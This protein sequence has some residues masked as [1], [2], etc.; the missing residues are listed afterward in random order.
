MSWFND[1]FGQEIFERKYKGTAKDIYEYVSRLSRII[2]R[3]NPDLYRKF[4]EMILS[5]RFIPGGRILA[6]GGRPD[7]NVSLMNCTTHRITDDSLEGINKASY[8]VM[9]A[10]SRGQGI[11]IDLTNLRPKDSPVNN[12]ART[13]TGAIS[14]MELLNHVAGTIGQEGRRA[15]LLF[16]IGIDHPDVYRPQNKDAQCPKCSGVGCND[17]LNGYLP[18]DFLHVKHIPGK[19]ENANISVRVTDDF[20]QA[21]KDNKDWHLTFTG[22]SGG[23]DFTVDNVYPAKQ[24]F[25]EL[26]RAAWA[27][28]EPGLLYWNT[29][30]RMSNSDLFGDEWK[31]VGTNS[32]S[33]EVLDQDG[34]CLLGSL[35]LAAYVINPFTP[36]ARFDFDR[37]TKDIQLAI[38][39]LDNVIDVE[40]ERGKHTTS[41]QRRSLEYLRRIGL[42]VMGLADM[43]AMLG[44]SYSLS[45]SPESEVFLRQVFYNLAIFSYTTS[46][47][48]AK[49]R[50]PALAW[51]DVDDPEKI[52]NSGFFATLS[53]EIKRNIVKYGTR[54]IVLLSIAPTGTI[55]NLI[56]VT[57]GIEPLF[58]PEFTRRTRMSGKDEFVTYVHPGIRLA[59]E[60][61]LPDSVYETAYDLNVQDH[62]RMQALVQ[63]YVDASIAKTLNFPASATVDDVE[64]AYMTG[65]ELGLKG[66]A[67]YVDGSR[68]EQVLYREEK[69]EEET[70]DACGSHAI[71]HKEGCS[72]CQDCG[73]GKCDL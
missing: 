46:I 34:V 59:R 40:L 2:S 33:E 9:R 25:R 54:N 38:T 8:T 29:S 57:G 51:G 45:K 15:A 37:F 5:K 49:D 70:C 24:I 1:P 35:N 22:K 28:A 61:G 64:S 44:L 13:S 30:Q 56:G 36:L 23:D 31:I 3:G 53:D 7:A 41:Q 19:V 18:Y 72:T 55:S 47:L 65:W 68:S 62:L 21:V 32:C 27:S 52:V 48:L 66:M 16:S 20:M 58:A 14:F 12:A 39:F 60:N 42:G 11:G 26:A 6:F 69:Q 43:L 73:W 17:C 63:E 67:I 10:S 4:N 50:G 71:A